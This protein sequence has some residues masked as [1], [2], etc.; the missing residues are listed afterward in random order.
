MAAARDD[1]DA[2]AVKSLRLALVLLA[3]LAVL[4]GSAWY[5][6]FHTQ[7]GARWLWSQ[8]ERATGGALAARA[9]SGDLASGLTVSEPVFAA[10][11]VRISATSARLDVNVDL[12]PLTVTVGTAQL[13]GL[14][15]VLPE[16]DPAQEHVAAQ[17]FALEKLQLPFEL[18]IARLRL[19]SASI[20][21][22]AGQPLASVASAS[23]AARWKDAIGVENL[24][25]AMPGIDASGNARLV[26]QA[27]YTI[28]I[29]LQLRA[30][31]ETTGLHTPLQA[32]VR[33]A[34][35]LDDFA[36]E[37]R[38][39]EPQAKLTGTVAGITESI[40]WDLALEVPAVTLPA[41]AQLA[42]VPPVSLFA[43]GSGG[44]KAFTVNATVRLA[45]TGSI[46]SLGANVDIENGTLEGNVDWRDAQWPLADPHPRVASHQGRLAVSGSLDAWLI[47]GTVALSVPDLPPGQFTVRG[48]GDR[49][50]AELRIL[51]GEV[52]GG[53]VAGRAQYR[54]RERPTWSAN[55]ELER[56]ETD[57][58][59]PDWPATLSGGLDIRGQQQPFDL[60]VG[61][62]DVR[63]EFRDKPLQAHGSVSVRERIVSAD[64]LSLTHGESSLQLDGS[65]YAARGLRYSASIE[66]LGDYV[67]EAS[68][69]L[70]ASGVLSLVP[71][72]PYLE[73]RASSPRL[74]FREA[75]VVDLEILD[76][77]R[78]ADVMAF[79]L[80]ASEARY[81]E[82]VASQLRIDAD[83]GR[84]LQS[85]EMVFSSSGVTASAAVTGELDDWASPDRWSG[86][87]RRLELTHAEFSAALTAPAGIRLSP[88]R[89][90]VENLCLANDSGI[91]LCANGS[92]SR[93]M[94]L[95]FSAALSSVPAELLNAFVDSGL[96][97]DQVLSGE[98][99]WRK[100]KQGK[101]SG[102]VDVSMTGGTV[103]S[104][105]RPDMQLE[106]G[107]A[108][109]H[110]RI[111]ASSLRS[112]VLNLPL[113][114]LGQVAANFEVLDVAGGGSGQVRG[115]VDVDIA[116]IRFV[117]A[118]APVLDDVGGRLSADLAIAGSITEPAVSGDLALDGG[119]VSYLPIGLQLTQL[120]LASELSGRGEIELT[121][122]FVAGEGRGSIRTRAR[123]ARFERRGLQVE[124]QGENLTLI[125]VADLRA[126]ANTDLAVGF[127]GKTLQ[128]DGRVEV[129]HARARPR[130]IGIN[131][132]S[133]SGDVVIVRGD[134]PD[135]DAARSPDSELLINGSVEV[136]LGK[137][138]VV[139]LDVADAFVTGSTVFSWNGPAMPTANGRYIVN[140]QILAYG[141]KLEITEGAVRF[142]NVP[143]RDPYL[144][145]RAEREIF[146]NTEVRR[147][148]VLV[149]GPASRPVI[150]AYTTPLTTEERALTLLVTGSEFDYEKGVGAF[151]F[152]TYIAPRVYASY[153]IGLFDQENIIRVR[154]DLTEGFG[155]TLTS[156]QRDEGVDLSYRISN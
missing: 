25:L 17:P 26:L 39:D 156:G 154:Y 4:A 15:V 51:D 94:G 121:G 115:N 24:E 83:A 58:L 31:P 118:F 138:V 101:S 8:A 65:P 2:A 54:W 29:D 105:A 61:L 20:V 47:D 130:N 133:E 108:S 37:V 146:G 72:N 32:S 59:L 43:E 70:Q 78:E 92:W 35:P 82:L 117:E 16:K 96:Q 113:P 9:V 111:D 125:D 151:D 49:D 48:G 77:R 30:Q 119:S 71:G 86:Q 45:G 87:V 63:G 46:A 11:G 122:S 144:R 141:Q 127:D 149:S 102:R 124:L 3:A 64:G 52:L 76:R 42:E 85:I 147:A 23:F 109:L 89:T 14:T 62:R 75:A 88:R 150:E 21:S 40:H 132:V 90:A 136:A 106:T 84:Q 13:S 120:S 55:L 112:G 50:H 98:L 56:V 69:A 129:P 137:D 53:S 6:L 5:S 79:Q 1:R 44:T 140:G 152:G 155:I 143:A 131:R 28:G 60:T 57:A 81:G 134:L 99:D 33:V 38:S 123:G 34:G 68:G 114:G 73:I 36:V 148:G 126:V 67:D 19:D 116:D 10:G 139:D 80:T 97:F 128:L 7:P 93:S 110:F 135:G 100:T 95:D 41:E 104:L 12:V 22:A 142:P 153:G 27:P 103:V 18:N 91:S 66:E 145:I 74:G 107:A